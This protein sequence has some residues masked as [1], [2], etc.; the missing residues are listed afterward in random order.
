MA[1]TQA[2]VEEL[3]NVHRVG[4]T[5]HNVLLMA[6]LFALMSER[7]DFKDHLLATLRAMH[8]KVE[9]PEVKAAIERQIEVVAEMMN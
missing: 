4:L 9:V 7:P 1:I 5:E 6:L 8:K 3:L 2:D